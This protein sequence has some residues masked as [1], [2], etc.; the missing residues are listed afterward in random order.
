MD[1]D[2]AMAYDAK[3]GILQNGSNC[4]F[5]ADSSASRRI[6]ERASRSESIFSILY[7]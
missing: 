2:F 5:S 3:G 1:G 6:S 4:M 7:V